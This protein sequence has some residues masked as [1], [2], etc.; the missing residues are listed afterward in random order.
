MNEYIF[1]LLM[2]FGIYATAALSLNLVVGG[3]GLL[4]LAHAAYFSVGAYAYAI[5][6][7][8]GLNFFPALLL[9]VALAVVLSLALS[10]PAWRYRGDYF[11]L[12]SLAVQALVYSAVYNWYSPAS[13]PGTWLN[14]TNGS[15]GLSGVPRP[16]IFGWRFNS[17]VGMAGLSLS[18]AGACAL[19][20][21]LLQ[22]SPWWRMVTAMRDDEVAARSIG[23][24]VH[25]AKVQVLALACGMVAAAGAVF[26]AYFSNMHPFSASLTE[27]I[28]IFSMV[29]VGGAGNLR[30]P[31]I[32]AGLL[33]AIPELLRQLKIPSADAASIRLL[34]YGLLLVV[35]MH[36]RS[37]GL[38]GRYRIE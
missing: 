1:H 14:L 4:S 33:I 16:V 18:L 10:I 27:G 24:N 5:A 20:S 17:T 31:L 2:L 28:L 34:L 35:L 3:A 30:G 8:H 15:Y 7:L 12:V 36:F 13:A 38:A 22:S 6:S 26:T 9:G 37:Q 25:V 23:K 32:G 21:A 29:L 11:V 19:I